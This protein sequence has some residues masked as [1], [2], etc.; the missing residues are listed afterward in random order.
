MHR[1][2]RRTNINDQEDNRAITLYDFSFT[3]IPNARDRGIN[4]IFAQSR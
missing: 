2:G 4:I 1:R 3:L